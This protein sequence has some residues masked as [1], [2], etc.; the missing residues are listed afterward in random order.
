M[1][2]T[3]F[4]PSKVIQ[5]FYTGGKVA[6]DRNGRILV[7]TLGEDVLVTD[8]ETGDELARIEGDSEQ[9]TTLALTPDASYLII[10]SRSYTMRIYTLSIDSD[11]E[12]LTV[13]PTLQRSMKAHTSPIIVADTDPTGTLL[14]I[15]AADGL[16]KVWDIKGGYV[17][18]NLHGHGGVV[19][20]LR[21]YAPESVGAPTQAAA[22]KKGGKKGRSDAGEMG[23][24][25][26]TGADDTKVRVWD[27]VKSTCVAVLDS[28][29]SVVR[30]LD[31]SADGKTLVSGSRDKVVC[32]WDTKSWKLKGTIPVLEELEMVGFL[33]P[34]A[35]R[36]Q[37]EEE[38]TMGDS[39]IYMGGRRNRIRLWD[40]RA[41]KEITRSS[42]D[43]EAE[44][45]DEEREADGIVDIIYHKSLPSLISIHNDQTI[46]VNSL[47]LPPTTTTLP[48]TRRVSGHHDEIIDLAYLTPTDTLVALATNSEDVRIVDLTK[49]FGDVGVLRG[50]GDIV[51]CLDRDWS[52]VWLAT[53]GKDNEARLWHIDGDK[54][55]FTCHSRFVGHAES[56]GA[57]A[58]SRAVPQAESKAAK[59]FAP[60]KFV[61]TGSQDRTIKRWD[62]PA[63]GKKAKA[64]YTRKAHEK[65]INAIDVS[66]DDELF[67][68][69][70]QDKTVKIWSVQEGEALGVLRGHRRGVWSVKFGPASVTG[71]IVGG[72]EGAKGGRMVVT[73]SGDKTVKLWSLT[74]Y[75]CLKT[76]EGH[77]NSVLKTVW[78]SGGL[79]VGSSGGDGLVKV[80]DVKSGECNATLDNHEDKVWA[81]TVRKDD[82][83]LV[84]GGGDS[85][86]TFWEDISES[87]RQEASKLESELIEQE[88]KLQNYIHNSDYRSAITLAL[89]LNHPGRLLSLLT[90]VTTTSPAEP[91]SMSGLAAVDEVLASLGDEQLF[92]LLCR[93]RDWNTNAKTASVAQRILYVI[94]KSYS[95][96][97]LIE[98]K[99]AAQVWDAL[100]SYTER[101]YR[102]VEELVE[103][104]YLVEYTLREMEDVFGDDGVTGDE[105]MVM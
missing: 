36:I 43:E 93:V 52:G 62:I 1:L 80:W 96:Q 19:S 38:E 5:P 44:D 27:L 24:R 101:H 47:T 103:E 82:H 55:E 60:P 17:T 79:Q 22:A 86:V 72:A 15:G 32:V 73:G 14:A 7:T 84:S 33:A 29:V 57:I 76:F 13:T 10:C 25:L 31:W 59:S 85:V 68:S 6:L 3:D 69:A 28:H 4:K 91:N 48:V 11:L 58:L 53:G 102:R 66:P 46:L 95:P 18:H 34:G 67:A 49:G 100:K 71:A 78:L 50:H 21:F 12:K 65:D 35:L 56:I 20:A 30:G 97:R 74:D 89:G 8:F 81:L 9:V 70:S 2:K 45:D 83:V 41:G 88:Q 105:I 64:M 75:S 37:G 77:T 104:S 26:A 99:G 98:L 90:A 23:W 87:T 94:V 51:I 54:S 61:I 39:V 42:D 16:V 40:L 92:V 63:P